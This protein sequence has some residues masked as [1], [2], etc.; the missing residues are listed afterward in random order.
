MNFGSN[1]G[2]LIS[3][4]FTPWLAAR[5]GWEMA[6]VLAAVLAIVGA[7]LWLGINIEPA[8]GKPATPE[9]GWPSHASG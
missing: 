4:V 7:L 9:S 6:L 1:L 2:G 3:P 8:E 5:V